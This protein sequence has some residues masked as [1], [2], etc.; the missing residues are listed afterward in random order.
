MSAILRPVN[1]HIALASKQMPSLWPVYEA[2]ATCDA[3]PGA[4]PHIH[5]R[6]QMVL[7]PGHPVSTRLLLPLKGPIVARERQLVALFG[8]DHVA[9]KVRD[10]VQL[11]IHLQPQTPPLGSVVRSHKFAPGG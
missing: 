10:A 11:T 9:D 8:N 2:V 3:W 7:L 5:C 4:T 1:C 6:Q